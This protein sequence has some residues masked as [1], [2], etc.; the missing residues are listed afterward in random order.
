MEYDIAIVGMGPA[1]AV[2]ARQ[3]SGSKRVIAIDKKPARPGGGF[4]KPCGGM[5]AP[6]AQAVLSRFNITLPKDILVDPQIFSVKTIDLQSGLVRHY[7]RHYINMDRDRFDRW[8]LSMLPPNVTLIQDATCTSVTREDGGFRIFYTQNG[9]QAEARAKIIVGAD[10]ANS[11][12]RH[13]L[14]PDFRVHAFL[15][16]QQWFMDEHPSAFYSCVFDKETT[17]SYAWG[18]TKDDSFIFGGAFDVKTGKQ[19]FERLKAKLAPYGFKLAHPIKTEACLV[20]RPY[21][22]RNHCYGADGAFFIGE[23]AGFISPSSLEGISY[24]MKSAQILAD[25]LNHAPDANR[26]YRNR[27][28]SIRLKLFLKYVKFPFMYSPLLRR[29]VLQSGLTSIQMFED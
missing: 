12:V 24:A 29:L 21:G 7:K 10:G 20:L 27:T 9:T 19:D 5:L 23:A 17:D 28:R 16:I 2:L 26:A 1:G 13:A 14:Y 11:R 4:T 18:L 15:S 3:L 6:D 8:L 25:C 22:P